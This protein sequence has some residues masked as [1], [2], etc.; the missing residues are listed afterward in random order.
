MK[1]ENFVRLDQ[2]RRKGF[3]VNIRDNLGTSRGR[4]GVG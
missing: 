3:Y 1:N 4:E 2:F